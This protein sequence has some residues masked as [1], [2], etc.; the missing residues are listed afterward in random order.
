MSC[1]RLLPLPRNRA[2]LQGWRQSTRSAKACGLAAVPAPPAPPRP[3]AAPLLCRAVW[4]GRVGNRPRGAG[5]A[6]SLRGRCQ[7]FE[8]EPRWP[9]LL[10]RPACGLSS[11]PGPSRPLGLPDEPPQR[12]LHEHA[13][14]EPQSK[15]GVTL[16][17]ECSE[18]RDR[19]CAP[20][21]GAMSV[22]QGRHI[23]VG[24]VGTDPVWVPKAE[25]L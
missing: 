18:G 17:C 15:L 21:A 1:V 11:A 22:Y 12:D 3:S 7:L 4:P 25:S 23:A 5:W 9:F 16:E 8:S 20:Q 6:I 10:G 13:L 2:R 14:S 19:A 24:S